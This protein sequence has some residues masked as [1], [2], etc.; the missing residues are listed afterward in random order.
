MRC[1][2]S[3]LIDSCLERRELL[4]KL[5]KFNALPFRCG[6]LNIHYLVYVPCARRDGVFMSL[7]QQANTLSEILQLSDPQL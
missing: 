2:N 3:F 6:V 5:L 1:N 7:Y 4:L